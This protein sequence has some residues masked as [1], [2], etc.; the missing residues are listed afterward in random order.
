MTRMMEVFFRLRRF[1]DLSFG[2]NIAQRCKHRH[3]WAKGTDFSPQPAGNP[4]VD[5]TEAAEII[6]FVACRYSCR[7]P[8]KALVL[9]QSCFEGISRLVQP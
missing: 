5:V 6:D 7:V 4:L 8:H 3:H 2:A 9:C 1:H